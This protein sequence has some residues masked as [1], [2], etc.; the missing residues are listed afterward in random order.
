MA[1]LVCVTCTGDPDDLFDRYEK[2]MPMATTP[3]PAGLLYHVCTTDADCLCVTD[4]WE[5]EDAFRV[6]ARDRLAPAML[7]VGMPEPEVTVQQVMNI[8]E[9]M[10]QYV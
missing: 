7:E 8:V 10:P 5:S 9:A 2:A 1:V 3:F 4:V 6:F